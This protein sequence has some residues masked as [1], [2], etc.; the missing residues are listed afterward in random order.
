MKST[1][2][3]I[4]L[5]LGILLQSSYAQSLE[6]E[7]TITI[8]TDGEA[9]ITETLNTPTTTSSINVQ[10][11]SNKT[12]NLLAIDEKNIF[13]NNL[14][15]GNQL[16]IDSL[17]ASHVI[18]SYN[19]EIV[20]NDLGIWRVMY[21]SN[22]QS[23]VIL[24]PLSNIVSVNTIPIDIN[25]NALTM[26]PGEISISYT[27]REVSAKDFLV[28]AGEIQH[29]IQILTGSTIENFIYSDKNISFNVDDNVPILVIIP[30]S[31]LSE[32]LEVSLNSN[33]LDYQNYFQNNDEFWLRIEPTESGQIQIL[34]KT[35]TLQI[36]QT[37][38]Q[39]GGG[40]LIATATF[41][42]E[43]APQVQ[44]LR[45]LRDNTLLKTESGT[46]FME[47]FNYFYYSFSPYI[48]DYERE[49]PVFK[50]MVK[51]AIT[52]MIST[53]SIM[54]LAEDDAQVLG[55]GI[56]VIALNLG[57]Y[58]VAPMIVIHKVRKINLLSTSTLS[59]SFTFRTFDSH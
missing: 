18:L 36:S 25:D 3:L 12:S 34:E 32:P 15:N 38:E 26:P 59:K 28:Y 31:I 33:L 40:C 35:S 39:K 45:E 54:A 53:L 49:N 47:S 17:G 9:K 30:N 58:I 14:Q 44:Q 21:D 52:P 13:L 2:V 42:S 5:L 20:Q 10:L 41:G 57:M 24:P 50:E 51:I 1:S 29:T 56:S 16:R 8:S 6:N 43:L 23:T 11:V 7:L 46:L 55:L 22:L 4:L 37:N 48:A 19:A 27:L